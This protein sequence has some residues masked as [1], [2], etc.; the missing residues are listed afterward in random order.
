[1]L[2]DEALAELAALL[3]HAAESSAAPLLVMLA[4]S[5]G[6]GKSTFYEAYLGSLAIPF[7][8]ADRI[9]AELRAATRIWP[10]KLSGLAADEAARQLADEER[11]ASTVL[12]NDLPEAPYR[13]VARFEN[14]ALVRASDL[15]PAWA[16]AVLPAP[17]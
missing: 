8:N 6:A 3:D 13:F 5:N 14:G 15:V 16:Q 1:M 11:Q 2:L 17:K 12:R 9:A 7:I 4:G 10:P